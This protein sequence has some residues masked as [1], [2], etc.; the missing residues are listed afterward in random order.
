MESMRKNLQAS[1]TTLPAAPVDKAT[2]DKLV[3]DL[4]ETTQLT[5]PPENQRAAWECLLKSEILTLAVCQCLPSV[6]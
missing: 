3:E 4:L 2:L 1:L 5:I 6:S